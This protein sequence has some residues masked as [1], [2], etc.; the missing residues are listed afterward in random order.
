MVSRLSLL[1]G[2]DGTMDDDVSS[3]DAG[4]RPSG[5]S[6]SARRRSGGRP[7]SRDA[8]VLTEPMPTARAI[9]WRPASAPTA[10]G[11]EPAGHALFITQGALRETTRHVWTAPEQEVLGFL[12]GRR[13]V[14]PETGAS[15]VVISA[16]SQSSF[17][18]GEDD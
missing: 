17:V 12:F 9:R 2:P 14:C 11:E 6:G 5:R 3:P 4:Q 8:E 7:S 13:Y 10:D 16:T 1:E 18:V 15:Y